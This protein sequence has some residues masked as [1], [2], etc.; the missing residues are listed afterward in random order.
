M[1]LNDFLKEHKKGE[2]Q[3]RRIKEHG[4]MRASCR[5]FYS[6]RATKVNHVLS[7][8]GWTTIAQIRETGN[9]LPPAPGT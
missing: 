8:K 1:L 7:P 9:A 2:E 6:V 4:A 5:F 3:D